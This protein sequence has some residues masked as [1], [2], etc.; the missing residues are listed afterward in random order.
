MQKYRL[1][2][3]DEG[4]AE[5]LVERGYKLEDGGLFVDIEELD[6]ILDIMDDEEELDFEEGEE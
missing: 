6:D 4:V 3:V 2:I 1:Q 5:A